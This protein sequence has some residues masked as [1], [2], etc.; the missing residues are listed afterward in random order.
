MYWDTARKPTC[1]S[2]SELPLFGGR[3]L[4]QLQFLSSI[5]LQYLPMGRCTRGVSFAAC[6]A[7]LSVTSRCPAPGSNAYGQLG[8]ET[9]DES[10]EGASGHPFRPR[11]KRQDFLSSLHVSHVSV[12]SHH[13]VAVTCDGIVYGIGDNSRG[14]LGQKDGQ[15]Q[16]CS[17]VLFLTSVWSVSSEHRKIVASACGSQHTLLLSGSVR[18]DWLLIGTC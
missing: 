1:C 8:A 3:R 14:Q 7:A 15:T 18:D 11:P 9:D 12:G 17:P 2:R 6:F 4:L 5:P 16:Y 13:T 10:I